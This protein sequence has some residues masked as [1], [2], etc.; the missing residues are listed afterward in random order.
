MPY[1][2]PQCKITVIKRMVN[3]DLVDEYL[4]ADESYGA[5]D[6]FSEGQEFVLE[7]PFKMPEGFCAWA[8]ADIRGDIMTIAAGGDL[9][10]IKQRGAIITGCTDWFRPVIFKVER[11]E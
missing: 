2:M 7:H 8:W 6:Q 4:D 5:C 1:D 10:W 11:V 9:P 3:R